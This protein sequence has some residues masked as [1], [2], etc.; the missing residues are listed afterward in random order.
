MD[1]ANHWKTSNALS[2]FI[3]W[4]DTA[5]SYQNPRILSTEKMRQAFYVHLYLQIFLTEL[6]RR[7]TLS[8][9]MMW[10]GLQPTDY[11]SK[12]SEDWRADQCRCWERPSNCCC[13]GTIE[14]IL[15]EHNL[16]WERSRNSVFLKLLFKEISLKRHLECPLEFWYLYIGS[17]NSWGNPTSRY[18]SASSCSDSG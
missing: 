1:S 16:G 12:N 4:I 11:S 15:R 8:Y 18:V 3:Q 6:H 5:W 9:L 7:T 10:V 13:F 17:L 2:S 14:K